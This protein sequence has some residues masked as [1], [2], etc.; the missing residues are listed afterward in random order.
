MGWHERLVWHPSSGIYTHSQPTGASHPHH[1]TCTYST[2]VPRT[3]PHPTP[4]P[5]APLH[6][7]LPPPHLPQALGL[8]PRLLLQCCRQA[9]NV[10]GTGADGD[11]A[12][13][14]LVVKGSQGR[15]D[16][17]SEAGCLV[18]AEPLHRL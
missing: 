9:V 1:Q 3:P 11:Q 8:L 14:V 13:E 16:G 15:G 18:A 6:F 10:R 2:P 7:T 17:R 12:P 5:G 4:A